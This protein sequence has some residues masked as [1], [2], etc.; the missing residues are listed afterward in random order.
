MAKNNFLNK[1][2]PN[3]LLIIGGGIAA[4]YAIKGLNIFGNK[5]DQQSK[6][7]QTESVKTIETETKTLEQTLN[8]SFPDSTYKLAADY[9]TQT[10]QGC[11]VL[12]S[13]ELSAIEQV[14]KVVKNRLDW[15]K[16]IIAFGVRSIDNCGFL[17][18]ST[19]YNLPTLIKDQCGST[20]YVLTYKIAD[21]NYTVPG[22]FYSPY[23]DILKNYLRTLNISL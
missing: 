19:D 16:L 20:G 4:Y 2:N 22:G 13:Y 1:V 6:E 8:P 11:D 15:N 14:I 17:T 21:T 18:G 3:V 9:I 23:S 5:E 10:L 7:N 12:S